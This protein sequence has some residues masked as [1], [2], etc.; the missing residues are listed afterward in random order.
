LI[1]HDLV[2]ALA[3]FLINPKS[4]EMLGFG[5]ILSYTGWIFVFVLPICVGLGELWFK[6]AKKYI[7]QILLLIALSIWSANIWT[8]HPNRTSLFLA[9][10]F[11]TLPLRWLIDRIIVTKPIR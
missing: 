2:A 8:T 10:A 7:P 5:I 11:L 9:C 6:D 4:H 1:T 3:E